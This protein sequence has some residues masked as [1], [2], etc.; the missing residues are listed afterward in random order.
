VPT[1]NAIAE[2]VHRAL[3]DGT[4]AGSLDDRDLLATLPQLAA[5]PE[6]VAL[7]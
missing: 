1:A 6:R 5:Q 4:P 3:R 7:N 2:R